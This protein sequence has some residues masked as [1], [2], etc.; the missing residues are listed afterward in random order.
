MKDFTLD[1]QNL[2]SFINFLPKL[3]KIIYNHD[4]V[5]LVTR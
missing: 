1:Y 3:K 2:K 4:N 5:F